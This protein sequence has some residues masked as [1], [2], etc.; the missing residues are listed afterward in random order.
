[1]EGICSSITGL[2]NKYMTDFSPTGYVTE[3]VPCQYST[4]LDIEQSILDKLNL[5]AQNNP[6]YLKQ[7]EIIVDGILC[8]SYEGDINNYWLSSKKHDTCYQPFYPTWIL[9]AYALAILSKKLGFTELV[10]IGSGDGRIAYCS[11]L[12]GLKSF[13]IE[14]DTD[15]SILQHNVVSSTGVGFE[16]LN[17]DATSFDYSSLDLSHPIFFISG[18]PE[19]GDILARDVITKARNLSDAKDTIGFNFMGTH[20]MREYTADKTLWGWGNIIEDFELNIV[21][22]VTLPTLWTN[23]QDLDTA[24]VFAQTVRM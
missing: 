11:T 19:L 1:M 8:K 4:N 2:K 18:L 6:I 15:L 7:T 23:D 20:V 17:L 24:Y 10:D 21:G 5:F 9:S 13:S 3:I 22:C 14:I 12:V 16:I